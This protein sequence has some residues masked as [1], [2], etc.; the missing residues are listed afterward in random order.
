MGW[1][2]ERGPRWS[3]YTCMAPRSYTPA[4]A[5]LHTHFQR[6]VSEGARHRGREPAAGRVC[7]QSVEVVQRVEPLDGVGPDALEEWTGRGDASVANNLDL[8]RYDPPPPP[9]PTCLLA[10]IVPTASLSAE[11]APS[12]LPW[13]RITPDRPLRDATSA[14]GR[15][16]KG[17]REGCAG[18]VKD[19]PSQT[20]NN[21]F[22]RSTH[23]AP[24]PPRPLP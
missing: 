18:Q 22:H 17:G 7:E 15:G 11:T 10:S 19:P 5:E 8:P 20:K 21:S 13:R 6:V 23:S 14:P 9:L 12:K 4:P 16:S 1:R 3:S 2:S 24:P